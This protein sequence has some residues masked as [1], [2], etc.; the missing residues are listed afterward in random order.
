MK[1]HLIFKS[2]RS[3]PCCVCLRIKHC[4][5]VND[6]STLS[7]LQ[8]VAQPEIQGWDLIVNGDINTGAAVAVSGELVGS[9]GG[10]QKVWHSL[11]A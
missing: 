4:V 6:G 10:K 9:L 11:H 8:I 3:C 7:G 5:Q 2:V 1:Q